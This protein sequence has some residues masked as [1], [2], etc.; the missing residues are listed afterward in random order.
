MHAQPAAE[1][2]GTDHKNISLLNLRGSSGDEAMTLFLLLLLF[3]SPCPCLPLSLSL[4]SLL[5]WWLVSSAGDD[6]LVLR[7]R[8]SPDQASY[9]EC[10]QKE[11]TATLPP[12][13]FGD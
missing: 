13:D 4:S 3:L 8:A 5:L 2:N 10:Q 9:E 1:Q 7:K 12:P 6:G 11:Y